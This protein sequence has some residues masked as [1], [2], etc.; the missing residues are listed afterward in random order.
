MGPPLVYHPA[1]S[2]P[3][4]SGHR[5]PMQ[6]FR[7]LKERLEHLELARPEQIHQ[8]L[9]APRRWLEQVHGR[10]Y[11]EAFA[12]GLLSPREVRRIGLPVSW[13]LVRRSWMAVGGTVLTARLALRHGLACHLAGGTHHAFPLHGSGFCIFNDCAVAARVLLAEGRVRQVLVVDLDVH[14]G[15]GTAA[16]FAG[17]PRVF[18]FSMH[19]AS[20]FPLHKQVS[21]RDLALEDGVEDDAYLQALGGTLPDLLA[22]V[23]PDLVLYNAGVD[24][25]RDDRLGRLQL[26]DDGLYRRDW[27]VIDAALRRRIPVATVI[28]G[29]YDGLAALVERHTLV[30]RA[31]HALARIHG[32]EPGRSSP[33]TD[34][35][36][37]GKR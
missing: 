24:P 8:P 6:K 11:H 25:H 26:S 29:G 30:V 31:A 27:M 20:N 32:T 22:Q 23:Q 4:P 34:G 2:V 7:L 5:F 13:P 36:Q 21:D 10:A 16:I 3:L 18:T 35:P 1:Y 19:G 15:D 37:P 9:P 17:D 12:R 14:Q 33:V 28:G